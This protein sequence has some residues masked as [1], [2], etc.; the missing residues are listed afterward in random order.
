MIIL[1]N[2][3][4]GVGK[5]TV[6]TAMQKSL[7]DN[8]YRVHLIDN[9]AILNLVTTFAERGSDM[10]ID[11]FMKIN[12]TVF[13]FLEKH[14]KDDIIIFTNALAADLSEDLDRYAIFP[15]LAKR[16]DDV[17]VPICLVCDLDENIRRL[18]TPSRADKQ[19]LIDPDIF[20]PLAKK[21]GIY[22]DDKDPNGLRIDTTD[23][24]AGDVALKIINHIQHL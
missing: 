13:S 5:L 6:A 3:M 2:A 14:S 8:G 16:R 23:M 1:I 18:Q 10:Y 19:K 15:D 9:H 21:H 20:I 17:F 22:C 12:E 11:A 7:R 4:P 24:S